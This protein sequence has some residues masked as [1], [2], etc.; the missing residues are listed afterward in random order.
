MHP[1]R[2]PSDQAGVQ[3]SCVRIGGARF[4]AVT[5]LAS[6]EEIIDAASTRRGHWTI[7]ANADHLRRYRHDPIARELIDEADLVVADGMPLIWASRLAGTSLPERV[8]GSNMIWSI[9][10]RACRRGQSVML[11]GGDPGIAP[12]AGRVLRE[13]YPGLEIA[14]T[15]CPPYGFEH[16]VR[17]IDRLCEQ[18]NASSPQIVF[19]ALGFPKQDVL[20]RRLRCA[21]PEASFIGVGISLSFV[22]GEVS[23]APG[24]M[25]KLG[26]EWFYRLLQEPRRLA[27]RY[28]VVGLPFVLLL[29]ASALVH[30]L[31]RSSHATAVDVTEWG[32]DV[33]SD[34][35]EGFAWREQQAER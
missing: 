10:E 2:A 13:R 1:P 8:A 26:L 18:V 21:L 6:V 9:C 24:W 30:R 16:D 31:I 11:L 35:P 28:L 3:R 14:G 34:P 20:I 27:H 22:A 17:E 23:R 25:R 29:L 32:W 7:T 15:V 5:E 19:V 4:A 12:R 33:R